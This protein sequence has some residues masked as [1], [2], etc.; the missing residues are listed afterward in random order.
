M[1]RAPIASETAS[2]MVDE[3]RYMVCVCTP[4]V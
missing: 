1:K 3:K 2:L 4:G